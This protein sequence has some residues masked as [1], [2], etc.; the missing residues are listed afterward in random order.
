V[1]GQRTAN[2]LGALALAL[3]DRT[4]NAVASVQPGGQGLSETAAAALSALHHFLDR[5]TLDRLRQVLG[6]THSGAVRLVDRL[7][8]A[9]LVK[10][11]AGEDNRSRS[12]A[13][14]AKGRRLAERITRERSA[15]LSEALTGLSEAEVATLESLLGRMMT[16][17]VE[18]KDGGAW[19]CRLCDLD[20]CERAQGHCPAATAAARKYGP[21]A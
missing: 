9:G 1:S 5:P 20:A 13:L 10:R 16:N 2:V 3:A 7:S 21:P 19:I 11:E 17:V 6:L 12:V 18:A 15:A 8:D 4:T 14:T